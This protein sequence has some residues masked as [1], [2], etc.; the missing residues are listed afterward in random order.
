MA[1]RHL[2]FA[3]APAESEGDDRLVAR[4]SPRMRRLPGPGENQAFG[5]NDL[6]IKAGDNRSIAAVGAAHVDAVAAADFWVRFQGFGPDVSRPYPF[7]DLSG[8]KPGI[9]HALARRIEAARDDK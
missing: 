5:A 7:G 3:A 2:R 9:E 6:A 4:H 8:V 1:Q